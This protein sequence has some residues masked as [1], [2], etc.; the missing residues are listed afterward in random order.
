[1]DRPFRPKGQP[2]LFSSASWLLF[3]P[4]GALAFGLAYWGFQVCTDE[5]CASLSAVQQVEKSLNLLWGRGNY[6]IGRDPWQL[7]AA[8]WMVPGLALAAAAK[9]FL[10]GVRRDLRTAFARRSRDHV[11][12]CGLGTTGRAVAEVLRKAGERVV[13]ID[14]VG[15]SPNAQAVEDLGAPLI[16]GDA[17]SEA[18]LRIAGLRRAKALVLCTGTDAVNLEIAL[19]AV[20][21]STRLGGHH[22]LAVIPEVRT[23]WLFERFAGHVGVNLGN[24]RASIRFLSLHENAARLL[25]RHPF[26]DTVASGAVA[27]DLVLIGFGDMGREVLAQGLRTALALPGLRPR[28]TVFDTKGSSAHDEFRLLFPGADLV[29]DLD[30]VAA[31]VVPDDPS[32]W[33]AVAERLEGRPPVAVIVCLPKDE[34]SLFVAT[35]ARETLDAVDALD[36]A[37]FVRAANHLLADVLAEAE[38]RG[39]QPQRFVA[40]GDLSYLLSA[41]MLVRDDLDVLAEE[42]HETY[43]RSVAASAGPSGQ[44][45]QR[46]GPGQQGLGPGQQP[47]G[48]LPEIFKRSNR[49]FA[50]HLEVKLRSAGLR[51]CPVSRPRLLQLKPPENDALARAEHWRWLVE[52][53]MGGWSYGEPRDDR[54]KRHPALLDWDELSDE[55]RERVRDTI[56]GIPEILARVGRE[57]RRD[58]PVRAMNVAEAE[59]ILDGF[60]PDGEAHLVLAVDPAGTDVTAL[61]KRATVVSNV[62]LRYEA[63]LAAASGPGDVAMLPFHGTSPRFHPGAGPV[64]CDA[65]T[66]TG[67]ALEGDDRL[68]I[69]SSRTSDGSTFLDG[70]RVRGS[71]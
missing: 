51:S 45:Q 65:S 22:R 3:V 35:R 15:D 63:S 55:T 30:F 44:G 8:Q 59:R 40:Y 70:R 21:L 26:F 36:T 2:K 53:R 11:I 16:T 49:L 5:A 7:V 48:N 54:R 68:G 25:Y 32:S 47:W 56:A 17:T 67:S 18:A 41:S 4:V 12:V 33:A 28:V 24:E 71:P 27:P 6:T 61:A 60:D 57:I 52:R 69:G 50:D 64:G 1:M 13:A 31:R 14:M 34:E 58:R 23:S 19:S 10:I 43:R 20:E 38:T 62:T 42:N 39:G 46:S 66:E 29:A 9:L 37:I